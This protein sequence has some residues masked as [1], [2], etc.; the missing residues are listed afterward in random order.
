MLRLNNN[1]FSGSIPWNVLPR[2]LFCLD[3]SANKLTGT[4]PE[5]LQ[6]PA[7]LDAADFSHNALPGSLPQELNFSLR[8]FNLSSNVFSGLIPTTWTFSSSEA[9]LSLELDL[10]HNRL[11]GPFPADLKL[12][13]SYRSLALAGNLLNGTLPEAWVPPLNLERLDLSDNKMAGTIPSTWNLPNLTLASLQDNSFQGAAREC[14]QACLLV[15][16]EEHIQLH[17]RVP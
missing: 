1:S 10:S 2:E 5:A 12:P 16:L 17:T 11:S 3:L 14:F 7:G 15:I 9:G 6:L 13:D 4:L 8:S